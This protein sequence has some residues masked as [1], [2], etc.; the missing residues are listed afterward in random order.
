MV[1]QYLG[2]EEGAKLRFFTN[3]VLIYH[4]IITCPRELTVEKIVLGG[5]GRE[6]SS[7]LPSPPTR[8]SRLIWL[9][10]N[11]GGGWG[12]APTTITFLTRQSIPVKIGG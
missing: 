3:Q 8:S 7:V 5:E 1:Y 2:G 9:D 12:A 4:L 10:R 11:V 6:R